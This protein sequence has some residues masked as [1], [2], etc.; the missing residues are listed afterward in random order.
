MTLV[1]NTT[2]GTVPG[3]VSIIR[4][5]ISVYDTIQFSPASSLDN[6]VSYTLTFSGSQVE[7]WGGNTCLTGNTNITINPQAPDNEP[8]TGSIVLNNGDEYTLTLPVSATISAQDPSGIVSMCVYG[9]DILTTDGGT[10]RGEN[11]CDNNANWENY[12][13]NRVYFL[14]GPDDGTND[15]NKIAKILFQD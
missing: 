3:T 4:N 6:S 7:D 5:T 12:I 10:P 15:G 2:S 11:Y 1:N 14:A 13:I 8:P 9:A